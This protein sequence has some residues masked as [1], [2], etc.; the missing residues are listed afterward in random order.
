MSSSIR[1]DTVFGIDPMSGCSSDGE[2]EQARRKREAEEEEG[3]RGN[4][5]PT[6][7]EFR[8]DY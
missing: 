1:E 7:V 3:R 4:I 6:V 8:R 2:G 5:W